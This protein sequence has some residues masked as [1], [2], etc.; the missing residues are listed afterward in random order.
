LRNAGD[1]HVGRWR[2][3]QPPLAPK[4]TNLPI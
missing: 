2:E 4:A 3:L 1:P